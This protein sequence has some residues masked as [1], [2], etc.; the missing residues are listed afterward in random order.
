MKQL[1]ETFHELRATNNAYSNNM[2]RDSLK[3][4][5]KDDIVE[6]IRFRFTRYLKKVYWEYYE[7]G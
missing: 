1:G 5:N 6:E 2:I 7:E 4:I 3:D